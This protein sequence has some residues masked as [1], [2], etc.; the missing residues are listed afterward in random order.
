MRFFSLVLGCLA[1]A[2]HDSGDA[3]PEKAAALKAEV[4]RKKPP[5]CE[6]QDGAARA[7]CL[8]RRCFAKGSR[9]YAATLP[10]VGGKRYEIGRW[11]VASVT[12]DSVRVTLPIRDRKSVV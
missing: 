12:D 6:E 1:L 2:C 4:A 11:K 9:A 3:R 10:A 5:S 8:M 7:L